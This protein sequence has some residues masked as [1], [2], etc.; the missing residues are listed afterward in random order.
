MHT[1]SFICVLLFFLSSSH[2][3]RT[4]NALWNAD[5]VRL[6]HPDFTKAYDLQDAD[7]QAVLG[8]E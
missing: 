1:F 6:R 3:N 8:K 2:L 5:N 7:K 4:L